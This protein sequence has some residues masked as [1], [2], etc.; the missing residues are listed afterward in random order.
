[1]DER[2]T[3]RWQQCFDKLSRNGIRVCMN[4]DPIN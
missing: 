3:E 2:V 4:F 1:M